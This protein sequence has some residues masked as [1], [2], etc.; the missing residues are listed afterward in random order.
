MRVVWLGIVWAAGCASAERET[1]GHTD[2]GGI[3]HIDAPPGTQTD[4][5]VPV[6]APANIVDA[7]PGTQTVTLTQTTSST[8]T[9][10]HSIACTA[11]AGTAANTYYRVFDLAAAGITKA[12]NVTNVTFQVE[13]CDSALSNGTT[14]AVRVGTYA[15]TIGPTL[16]ANKI[17]ILASNPTVAVPQ[18]TTGATVDA[19]IA[20]LIPIGS[21]LVVEVDAPDGSN[22]YQM[23]M[24][25]NAGGQSAL[26]YVS[27]PGCTP[28]GTTP[29]DIGSLTSPA[30]A[31]DIL[32]TVTGTY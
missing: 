29:T 8:L 13:N 9:P 27:A 16:Q 2:A 30:S 6:D 22:V 12:F 31:I 26:G 32:L 5:A 20:A 23:Y 1:F 3:V 7:Q 19:P 15:G 10:N 18:T 11:A 24:G 17:T 21:K 25:S 14:V 28:P 4:A